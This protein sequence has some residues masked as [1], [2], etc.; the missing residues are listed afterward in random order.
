L[1]ELYENLIAAIRDFDKDSLILIEPSIEGNFGVKTKLTSFGVPNIIFSPHYYDVG[2][3]NGPTA[4]YDRTKEY[5]I[6]IP[7]RF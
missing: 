7:Q 3:L 5:D 4:T 2:L 6:K 1:R